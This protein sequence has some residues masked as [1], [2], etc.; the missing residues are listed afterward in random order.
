MVQHNR[1]INELKNQGIDHPAVLA[2]IESIPREKFV[3]PSYKTRAYDNT[4][5]PIECQQTISQP[6]IVALM[7]QALFEHPQPKKILEIGTGSGYQ[8]AILAE[9]FEHVWTIE[10]IE[11][12]YRK[13]KHTLTQMGY[14]NISFK[15]D[16][17]TLGWLDAAPFDGILVTA[18]AETLPPSLLEQLDP[19]GGVMV[20]PL[21]RHRLVQRLT[22]IKRNGDQFEQSFIESVSFVPLI[23]DQ[24]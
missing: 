15:H 20:I 9:L 3:L 4:A 16:D 5:L 11:P 14:D 1:L 12:L 8:A 24:K 19:N 17:G 6:Y 18:A 23:S 7:T 22:L 21:G 10:R 2:A 13:A